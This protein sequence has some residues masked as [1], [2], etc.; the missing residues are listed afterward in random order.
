MEADPAL[1]IW[2]TPLIYAFPTSL[3]VINSH[4]EYDGTP[5]LTEPI[6]DLNLL[7]R[8]NRLTF[9][10]KTKN[11]PRG[12]T[13]LHLGSACFVHVYAV[14]PHLD[15]I[16]KTAECQTFKVWH[17]EVI[18]NAF[19]E[20]REG[21]R[22]AEDGPHPHDL[23]VMHSEVERVEMMKPD[24][25]LIPIVTKVSKRAYFDY[26]LMEAIPYHVHAAC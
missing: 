25:P 9:S 12:T 7:W 14:F 18:R 16:G 8:I 13:M 21:W 11:D 24:A 23:T 5:W 22:S 19:E 2:D 1:P 10:K 26:A 20:A 6:S 4:F 3:A 17:D 15:T